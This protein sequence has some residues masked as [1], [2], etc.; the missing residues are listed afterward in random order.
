MIIKIKTA[1]FK[2]EEVNKRQ[3]KKIVIREGVFIISQKKIYEKEL[4]GRTLE[5]LYTFLK[6]LN[7]YVLF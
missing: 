3:K 6:Y 1:N 7:I 5:I 4:I 2:E